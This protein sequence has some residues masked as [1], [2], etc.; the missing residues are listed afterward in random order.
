MTPTIH[1]GDSRDVLKRLIR[2][3]VLFDSIVTDPPYG[4]VSVQKRFGSPTAAPARTE[5]NDGSFARLSGGFMGQSWDATGIERDPEFWHLCLQALKPGGFCFAFS[6]SRTGHWQACAMEQAG[7]IMHP[8]HGWVYGSG[9]PKAHNAARAVDRFLGVEGESG[10]VI[11]SSGSKRNCMAGDFTGGDYRAY[12]PGSSEAEK[13]SGWAYG[14]QAQK[15]A[16]EPIYL[17]QRPFSTKTGAENLLKHGVGAVNIDGCRVPLP[18]SE[19]VHVPQSDPTKRGQGAGEYCLNGR[20]I[21]TMHAAQRAS[22]ERTNALGRYPANLLHDGSAEVEALFPNSNGSGP[23]RTLNRGKR[24]AEGGWGMNTKAEGGA[25]LPDAGKGS[26]ARFF[27]SAAYD[28]LDVPVLFYHSKANKQDRGGSK[29]PTVKPVG[30]IRYLVRHI[31]PPGGRVLDPFAGTGT[32]ALAAG[33]EGM[34]CDLIEAHPP[35]VE[36][37]RDRFGVEDGEEMI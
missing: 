4:L 11:G 2:C 26:A 5:G 15:P 30:L 27:Y 10:P 21:D 7:F 9:F 14:T 19:V 28:D 1:A 37:L 23:A 31:T 32:T 13:W 34:R 6:G 8:M 20:E 36:F 3:G 24:T 22:V 17:A 16:L 35:Y 29:H 18:P 25:D 33:L 12:V